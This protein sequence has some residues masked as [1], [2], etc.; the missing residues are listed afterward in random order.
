MLRFILLLLV[1]FTISCGSELTRTEIVTNQMTLK[2]YADRAI[3]EAGWHY[4]GNTLYIFFTDDL[5]LPK[6]NE[7][8]VASG[9]YFPDHGVVRI[10]PDFW[11]KSSDYVRM[12][13]MKHEIGH[14][15]LN[16]Q[17]SNNECDFMYY[18]LRY[19]PCKISE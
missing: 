6:G 1:A 5:Q 15:L 7:G 3:D 10:K 8:A 2:D 11:D 16:L 14:A 19:E 13:I 12:R 18:Q 4:V 17:H 9:T